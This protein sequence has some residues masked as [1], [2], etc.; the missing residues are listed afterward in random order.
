MLT[1]AVFP[2]LHINWI[3]VLCQMA[4]QQHLCHQL[5]PKKLYR[6]TT[7]NLALVT[8]FNDSQNKWGEAFMWK[9]A[10]IDISIQTVLNV[11]RGQLKNSNLL[12][13]FYRGC[14][15]TQTCVIHNHKVCLR[16]TKLADLL[17][18]KYSSKID[19]LSSIGKSSL[20]FLC[21]F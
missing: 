19:L 11:I 10:L 20:K 12:C 2:D 16:N 4:C 14:V 18:E 6:S 9:W 5:L 21:A 15:K 3:V 8:G 7:W 17:G 1:L 13:K